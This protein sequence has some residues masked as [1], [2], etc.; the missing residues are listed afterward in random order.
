M[1]GM[2]DLGNDRQSHVEWIQ[3]QPLDFGDEISVTLL[4]VEEATPPAEDI[5]S[6]SDE[7]IAAQAMYEAQLAAGLPAPR[8]PDALGPLH[9]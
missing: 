8:A 7:H 6:D 2:R 3:E 5:A 1:R 9:D 4:E